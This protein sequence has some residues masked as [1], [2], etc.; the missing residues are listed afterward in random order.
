MDFRV[1]NRVIV[2]DFLPCEP[3]STEDPVADKGPLA[4]VPSEVSSE[5]RGFPIDFVATGEVANVLLLTRFA[6]RIPRNKIGAHREMDI[7]A[8]HE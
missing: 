2:C 6:I 5:V 3:L 8:L 4:V 1:K 7:F